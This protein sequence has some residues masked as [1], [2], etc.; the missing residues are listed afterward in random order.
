MDRQMKSVTN[1]LLVS[2][3]TEGLLYIIFINIQSYYFLLI[4]T[5]GPPQN[6][7]WGTSTEIGT[8]HFL[9]T[10]SYGRHD[11]DRPLSLNL[12]FAQV[13]Q[14]RGP[15]HRPCSNPSNLSFRQALVV[16]MLIAKP[17][18]VVEISDSDRVILGIIKLCLPQEGGGRGCGKKWNVSCY[19]I[20]R[21][22]SV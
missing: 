13:P 17:F 19:Y 15:N 11:F 21:S 6:D 12:R 3:K 4:V 10:P 22:S 9:T 14:K 5:T 2:S 8:F 16:K 7:V 1:N 18:I 20:S